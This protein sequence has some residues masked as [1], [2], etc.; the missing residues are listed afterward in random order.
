MRLAR[1]LCWLGLML[2]SRPAAAHP[3]DEVVQGAYL[4]LAPGAVLLELDLA[5]GT[6]VAA[7]VLRLLDTDADRRISEL[8]A[9]AFAKLVLKQ[10]AFAID[11]AALE[12]RLL[13]VSAP[14]YGSIENAG[15]TLKIHAV[16][17]RADRAGPHT[18]VYDNQYAPAKSR[19]IANVF[20]QPGADWRHEVTGQRHSADGRELWVSFTTTAAGG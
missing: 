16:A 17:M 13:T 9:Q 6:L 5:P 7:D 1:R 18:L 2:L 14:S 8:E 15:D 10:S 12:W 19:C 11:G 20:L 3:V 4:T